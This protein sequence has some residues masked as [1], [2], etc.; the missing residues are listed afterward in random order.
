MYSY[1]ATLKNLF[2]LSCISHRCCAAPLI[3]NGLPAD[4][5]SSPPIQSFKKMLK[6][7][8]FGNPP[9]YRSL[10]SFTLQIRVDLAHPD[11]VIKTM[12]WVSNRYYYYYY[13]YYY[14]ENTCLISFRSCRILNVN[15]FDIFIMFFF[16]FLKFSLFLFNRVTMSCKLK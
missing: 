1:T 15:V 2:R 5:R 11:P 12:E 3:W 14:Y 13:Y 16:I 9:T 4:V 10:A 6:T 8:Y 7:Y